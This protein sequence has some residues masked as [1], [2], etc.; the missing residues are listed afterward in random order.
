MYYPSRQALGDQLAAKLD[1]YRNNDS[2]IFCVKES[3]L[4]TCV[5]LAARIH[6]YIYIL[7]YS[8]VDDPYD[9][10]RQLG[11]IIPNGDFILNPDISPSEYDYIYSNFSGIIDQGKQNAFSEINARDNLNEKFNM[12]VLNN[13][14]VLIVADI[15]K[16]T[17]E[18]EVALNVLKPYAPSSVFG[19]FGNITMPVSDKMHLESDG[20]SYM[21]VLPNTIFDDDHFFNQPDNYTEEQKIK[22]ANNISLYWA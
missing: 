21:D 6:A 14:N 19:A 20:L 4:L 5:E 9:T 8:E 2:I 11:A 12:D 15:L 10:T 22:L 3:S 13:R 17:F 16:T 7:Q 1:K 18:L